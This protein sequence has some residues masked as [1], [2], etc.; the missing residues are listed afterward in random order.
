MVLSTNTLWLLY[1]T[2]AVPSTDTPGSMLDFQDG[3][4]CFRE[5]TKTSLPFL[6]LEL[7]ILTILL[8]NKAGSEIPLPSSSETFSSGTRPL[9][10][11]STE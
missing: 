2:P 8:V 10:N 5:S 4:V 6:K 11:R 1:T 7:A 3:S 9:K